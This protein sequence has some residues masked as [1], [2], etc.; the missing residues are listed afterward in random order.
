[1]WF[2][3]RNVLNCNGRVVVLSSLRRHHLA[4]EKDEHSTAS[5]AYNITSPSL[6]L[7]I[8]SLCKGQERKDV[9]HI[10]R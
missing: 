4:L 3:S 1:M 8:E 6:V 7:V 5:M 10:Y 2:V 9:R